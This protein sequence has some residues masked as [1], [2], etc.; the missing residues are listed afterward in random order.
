MVSCAVEPHESEN[1]ASFGL[2][3]TAARYDCS[4]NGMPTF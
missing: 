1:Q 4:N 3:R 2:N